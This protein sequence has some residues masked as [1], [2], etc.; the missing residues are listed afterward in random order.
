MSS[1]VGP[2]RC[3]GGFADRQD[4]AADP[5][6]GERGVSLDRAD[7]G[8]IDEALQARPATGSTV[9]AATPTLSLGA[10]GDG[11]LYPEVATKTRSTS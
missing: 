9:S 10:E 7:L 2:F 5:A 4:Q 1:S 3:G 11:D 6:V 8:G